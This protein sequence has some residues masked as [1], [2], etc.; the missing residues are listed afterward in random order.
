MKPSLQ[1]LTHGFALS[2]LVAASGSATADEISDLKA[3][4][5]ILSDRIEAQERKSQENEKRA[6]AV[7]AAP[8]V[9]ASNG[10]LPV[11][12]AGPFSVDI[13][14]LL[15]PFVSPIQ[16][17]NSTYPAP[18]I[19]PNQ[20]PASAYS[21]ATNGKRT[22]VT[23]GSSNL[24]FR[25]SYA[26]SPEVRAVFQIE[27][28]VQIDGSAGANTL[29]S[30]NTW[31]G[32]Q[33]DAYGFLFVGTNFTPYWYTCCA[34]SILKGATVAD[35][36]L[37]AVP[38]FNAPVITQQ[39][40]RSGTVA[41]ATFERRQGNSINYWSPKIAGFS[42]RLQY[43]TDEGKGPVVANGPAISPA[44]TSASV[45]YQNGPLD[46]R[47]AYE[48]HRD[49]FGMAYLGGAAAATATNQHS[50]D[51]GNVI[52]VTYK[53]PTNTSLGVL[54]E[55]LKYS[56]A[57]SVV[58]HVSGY[59]RDSYQV[60]ATQTVGKH[61]A[62]LRLSTSNA[63]KCDLVGGAACSTDGLDAKGFSA[64]YLYNL[65]P[66]VDVWGALWQVKNGRSASYNTID[67][68]S[69][70]GEKITGLGVGLQFAF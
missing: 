9:A 66:S 54:A 26:F 33:S 4:V 24:G 58:G 43:S 25:G 37:L 60:F 68:S 21:A 13:Y 70:V 55:R 32:L 5:K 59:Q 44:V 10:K 57:D 62:S 41:D 61:T 1:A 34:A 52:N 14:G 11:M 30:R 38:G 3:Q 22:A 40:G 64:M 35:T 67:R 49:Y 46:V 16:Q 7:P 12:T 39:A 6:A 23:S 47:V 18:T 45:Y 19:G 31:V 28:G 51:T 69:Q 27:S 53:F 8:A 36:V 15:L 56:T 42:T 48:Q 17:T 29:A 2:L 50:R 65:M 20:V 63:G